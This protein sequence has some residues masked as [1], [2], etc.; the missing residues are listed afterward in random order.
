[1]ACYDETI[2]NCSIIMNLIV[3]LFGLYIF[4]TWSATIKLILMGLFLALN[5]YHFDTIVNSIN[6][7]IKI[8]L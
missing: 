7:N 6:T 1:M 8:I 5:L 3:L 4:S 2:V